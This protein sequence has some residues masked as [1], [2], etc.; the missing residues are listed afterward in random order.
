MN[1]LPWIDIGVAM[2]IFTV[3]VKIILFP[4]AKKSLLTQ[5]KMKEIEPETK[6]IREQYKNDRQVQAAKIM[7]LYKEKGFSPFSSIFLLIIQLPILFALISVFYKVIPNVHP[8]Y[9]YSFISVPVVTTDF[10]GLIDITHRS[11]VLALATGIIQFLQLYYSPAMRNMPKSD[12]NNPDPQ[13]AMVQSMNSGMKYFL[14]IFAFIST[15]WIIPAQFP[16]AASAIAIYWSTSTLFTL[17]QELYIR[18]KHINK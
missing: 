8:E 10:L 5:V 13:A 18:K 16:A 9:L 17:F 11:I 7:Q 4:L 2:V 15:Y 3:I 12:T 1:I 6:K 14:P